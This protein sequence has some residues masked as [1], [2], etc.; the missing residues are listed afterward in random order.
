MTLRRRSFRT[1][2]YPGLNVQAGQTRSG[3][4]VIE[5]VPLQQEVTVESARDDSDPTAN[6]VAV[7]RHS[8]E[9]ALPANGRD[10]H[11]YYA[12]VPEQR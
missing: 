3:D 10:L 9:N 7:S 12:I 6:G 5:L 2:S 1:A 8:S 4:F 11:A